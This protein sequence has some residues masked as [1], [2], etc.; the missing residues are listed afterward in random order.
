MVCKARNSPQAVGQLLV[1]AVL[2]TVLQSNTGGRHEL[3][4]VE[5]QG[6]KGPHDVGDA[7]RRA[8]P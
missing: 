6:G 7:L 3:G 8:V 2:Q 5:T 1:V 4:W